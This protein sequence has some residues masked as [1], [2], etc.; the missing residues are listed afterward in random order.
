MEIT[1]RLITESTPLSPGPGKE[2]IRPL[3]EWQPFRLFW[4]LGMTLTCYVACCLV[5]LTQANT[6]QTWEFFVLAL[7]ER[8]NTHDQRKNLEV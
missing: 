3:K 1:I 5:K 2:L 4:E 8:M 7:R 6:T